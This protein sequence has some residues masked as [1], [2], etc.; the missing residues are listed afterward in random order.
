MNSVF[1]IAEAGVNHNGDIILAY[2][3]V[4]E[5]VNAGA[6]AV[7]FQTAIPELTHR[8]RNAI[9]ADYW[10]KMM[11]K[12]VDV[13][14]EDKKLHL[15]LKAFDEL[16]IYCEKQSIEFLSSPWDLPSIDKLVELDV[17]TIKIPSAEIT[18]YPCL[19]KIGSLN[20]NVIMSVGMADLNEI[21]A[22]I[23]VL[24]EF[25]TTKNNITILHCNSEYP[26]P[27][28][29]V[30]LKAMLTLEKEFGLKVGYSDHTMGISVPIAAV[31]LGAR[32][33]EKHF[34]LD[35]NLRGPDH[36]ASLEPEEL[37]LMVKSIREVEKAFGSKKKLVSP[38]EK[39]NRDV[40]RKSI[41]AKTS[42]KAGDTFTKEN[43]T[44]KRPGTGINPMIWNKLIGKIA[45]NDFEPDEFINNQNINK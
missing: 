15:P 41:V 44:T 32:V 20:K 8:K 1:I 35:R 3:L 14:E 31:A 13:L 30:N 18:N 16:K 10:E 23:D 45:K 4:D 27:I 34:T 36:K 19:K 2:K 39:K 40:M 33:I 22:S 43:I 42:I 5:A 28:E 7:K 11:G 24:I 29:D 9:K 37:K 38:S 12:Q 25:G 17:D 21:R 26:T 6:D